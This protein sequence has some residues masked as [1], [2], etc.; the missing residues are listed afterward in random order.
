MQN[1]KIGENIIRL[2]HQKKIT[3]ELLRYGSMTLQSQ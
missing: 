1:L 2:R 3:Q